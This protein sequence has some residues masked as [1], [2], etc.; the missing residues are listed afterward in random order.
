[1]IPFCFEFYTTTKERKKISV[2][3]IHRY[4]IVYMQDMASS[5]SHTC[6][7]IRNAEPNMGSDIYGHR[8]KPQQQKQKPKIFFVTK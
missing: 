8:K 1:M 6:T 3:F 7:I 2:A 5:V 4:A